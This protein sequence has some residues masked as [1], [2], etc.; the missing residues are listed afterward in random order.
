MVIEKELYVDVKLE[1]MDID[2]CFHF[3]RKLKD[4]GELT[5]VH[6]MI[7][8]KYLNPAIEEQEELEVFILSFIV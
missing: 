8:S 7:S 3:Q 2:V 5:I 1:R 6:S 4:H